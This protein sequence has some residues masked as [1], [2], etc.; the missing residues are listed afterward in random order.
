MEHVRASAGGI[1]R[2]AVLM[3]ACL[4][5]AAVLT[6][7]VGSPFYYHEKFAPAPTPARPTAHPAEIRPGIQTEP[8][9]CGLHSLS[10]VY[11]AYGLD[12]EALRL[13]FRLGTDKPLNNLVPSSAGTIHPDMLRVLRQ[14]G[15]RVD[16]LSPGDKDAARALSAHLDTG[17]PAVALIKPSEFHWVVIGAHEGADAVI[18]DSLAPEPYSKP[19]D[20]YLRDDVYSLL[21]IAPASR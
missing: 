17:H 1:G 6:F 16:L 11:R 21:L 14:D 13:R 18:C 5:A 3:L 19:L 20:T 9:T 8:H 15:F 2:R 10:S 4:F 12:P 7:C